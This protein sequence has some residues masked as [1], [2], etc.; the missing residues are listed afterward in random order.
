[1]VVIAV[2]VIVY[3]VAVV[4]MVCGHHFCER[5]CCRPLFMAV[6]AAAINFYLWP[7]LTWFVAVIFVGIIAV[8]VIVC[9]RHCVSSLVMQV[10][11]SLKDWLS[12]IS[13]V[14]FMT[15]SEQVLYHIVVLEC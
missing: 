6:I 2:A 7:L 14:Q 11:R 10:N 13:P 3:P 1:M 9:G 4:N 12:R 15:S 5:H 8:G